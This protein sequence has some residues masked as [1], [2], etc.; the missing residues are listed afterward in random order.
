MTNRRDLIGK[1]GGAAL[2]AG[3]ATLASNKAPAA[4]DNDHRHDQD[5]ED[6]Y[7]KF[8]TCTFDLIDDYKS[9]CLSITRNCQV[10]ICEDTYWKGGKRCIYYNCTERPWYKCQNYPG[11]F[12][13]CQPYSYKVYTDL[14]YFDKKDRCYTH[15]I[16]RPKIYTCFDSIWYDQYFTDK[17]GDLHVTCDFTVSSW[18]CK[19]DYSY[20]WQC[21]RVKDDKCRD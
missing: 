17:C 4:P 7:Q 16:W 1:L 13:K 21:F 6:A 11:Y 9:K 12:F 15:K 18:Q 8:Y 10:S 5:C 19:V 20:D 2:I 3:A 14:D